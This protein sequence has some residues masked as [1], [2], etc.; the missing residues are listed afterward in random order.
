MLQKCHVG[1]LVW[2]EHKEFTLKLNQIRTEW[3][4]GNR[5]KDGF[6]LSNRNLNSHQ[7]IKE[8]CP[9]TVAR[10][11]KLAQSTCRQ[12]FNLRKR[13]YREKQN[14]LC[15]GC[16][17]LVNRQ[18]LIMKASF[19]LLLESGVALLPTQGGGPMRKSLQPHN[20]SRKTWKEEAT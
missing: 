11:K 1:F 9:E 16:W 15:V 10:V 14:A 2:Q 20:F 7:L 13:P 18:F 8:C 12:I 5:R 4:V 19:V 6:L 17:R 3:D